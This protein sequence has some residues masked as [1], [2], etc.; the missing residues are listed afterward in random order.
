[1]NLSILD[2]ITL[3]DILLILGVSELFKPQKSNHIATYS[4]KED[5]N[6]SENVFELEDNLINEPRRG[7]T[8][9]RNLYKS[10]SKNNYAPIKSVFKIQKAFRD[11]PYESGFSS[12]VLDDISPY[13]SQS[14][15]G[16]FTKAS[17]Y[18][19]KANNMKKQATDLTSSKKNLN[20]LVLDKVIGGNMAG[21]IGQ[22][23]K[24][25]E[26]LPLLKTFGDMNLSDVNDI[27]EAPQSKEEEYNEILSLVNSMSK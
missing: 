11:I 5:E 2:D 15:S 22:I 16:N 12:N 9:N 6:F 25:M 1:M 8:Y 19:S 10:L 7:K 23:T 24:M 17:S 27:E 18:I 3:V 13:L 21:Q 14:M 4:I 26:Y 20:K